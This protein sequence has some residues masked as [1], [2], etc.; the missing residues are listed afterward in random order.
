[1]GVVA[2]RFVPSEMNAT[3]DFIAT[4]VWNLDRSPALAGHA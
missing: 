1:M 4:D 3:D 2:A